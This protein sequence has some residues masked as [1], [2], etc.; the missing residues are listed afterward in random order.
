MTNLN[1]GL[2]SGEEVVEDVAITLG[3]GE[4]LG[5]VG[6][7]GS[8][9]TTTALALLGYTTPGVRI[10][11]GEVL[12]G[13]KDLLAGSKKG[14]R[15]SVVERSPTYPQDPGQALNPSRRIGDAIEVM[16]RRA[17]PADCRKSV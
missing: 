1:I 10:T 15:R 9:K 13:G 16:L 7:S 2:D 6:E 11:S 4:V 8:G 3:A 14:V 12:L 5:I 17:W